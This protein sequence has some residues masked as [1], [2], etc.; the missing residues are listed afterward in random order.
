[1]KR[2]L[3]NAEKSSIIWKNK[4]YSYSWLYDRI[5]KF[6]NDDS[7]NEISSGSVVAFKGDF[8][9]N[10]IALLFL[11]IKKRS[12]IVPLNNNININ[13]QKFFDISQVEYVCEINKEDS[14]SITKYSNSPN[15]KY[16]DII[17][18]RKH[19]GL[20]LFT[21]GTSGEPKAA[22]HDFEI[23]LKKF[24]TERSA[25]RT[26]NFLLFDHWGGLNTM[27]H[28]LSN[29]GAVITAKDRSPNN[30]CRLIEMHS[31]ELL[32]A[33]P[34]F[35]NL[36]M[37]SE[38]YKEYD[39]SSLKIISY[40][41][42]PMTKGTLLRLKNTFPKVKLLQTY[43]LIELGVL[44]SKSKSNDSLWV[45]IGGEGYST[46][47]RSGMLEIKADS[48][49]LGYLN[50]PSPF[51]YDGWFKTGDAVE[52][53]GEYFKILGRKSEIINVGGEK[54][55]PQ[56]VENVIQEIDNVKDVLVFGK[57][58]PIIG[59]M[60][61][62]KVQVDG[63]IDEKRLIKNIKEYCNQNLDR[64]KVP[65]KIIVDKEKQYGYRFKKVRN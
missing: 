10:T 29:G 4:Q 65:V 9:P 14:P 36:L 5:N 55:Y 42:E 2:F 51:T 17:K 56:E 57:D 41:T 13:D 19:P 34:T 6:D 16:Y 12:I 3:D 40:G 48:A 59:K 47:V 8:T 7:F 1:M 52:V 38:S 11:L 18:K 60:V 30:V 45:K 39:L 24:K 54:V 23:L 37:I 28:V 61:Y 22:V 33:S 44:R 46:R 35:L 58:N 49:M 21:S 25:L 43:G 64:F 53:D 20:V 50:A 63:N 62:A 26:I 15:N 31:I 32:P 27:F